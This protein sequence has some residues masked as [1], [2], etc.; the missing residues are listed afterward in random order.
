[1]PGVRS[2]GD[3]TLGFMN[4]KQALCPPSYITSPIAVNREDDTAM[5]E[6]E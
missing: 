5:T 3:L 1:M 6:K 2:G 4:T